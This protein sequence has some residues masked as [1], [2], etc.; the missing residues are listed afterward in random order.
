M[1]DSPAVMTQ[2]IAVK[3]ASCIRIDTNGFLA[4]A[5][6]APCWHLQVMETVLAAIFKYNWKLVLHSVTDDDLHSV[7]GVE[8]DLWCQS[9]VFTCTSSSAAAMLFNQARLTGPHCYISSLH[10][11]SERSTEPY[12][13]AR[14]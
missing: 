8:N 3:L 5:V 1:E 9:Y 14:S 7:T 2:C 11:I 13:D 4:Y 12:Q 10:H 6:H